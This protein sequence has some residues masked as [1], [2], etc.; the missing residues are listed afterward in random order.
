MTEES[1]LGL[2]GLKC[3]DSFSTPTVIKKK[4]K[5]TL[6]KCILKVNNEVLI[7]ESV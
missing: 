1:F 2:Q 5:V 6:K 7:C 3:I 4:V